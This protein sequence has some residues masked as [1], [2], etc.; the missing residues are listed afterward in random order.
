M[1]SLTLFIHKISDESIEIAY[2]VGQTETI[3]CILYR[4][5]FSQLSFIIPRKLDKLHTLQIHY[6][7]VGCPKWSLKIP[8]GYFQEGLVRRILK[9]KITNVLY[10]NCYIHDIKKLCRLALFEHVGFLSKCYQHVI[11]F[12]RGTI[13]LSTGL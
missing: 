2:R 6:E 7:R 8:N 9:K 5:S 11:F 12:L 1:I 13:F 3:N 10:L 4:S